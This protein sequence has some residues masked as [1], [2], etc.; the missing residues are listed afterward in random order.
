V[1]LDV[2]ARVGVDRAGATSSAPVAR[3]LLGALRG[4]LD[5]APRGGLRG[6]DG[7]RVAAARAWASRMASAAPALVD[8]RLAA[9]RVP[10]V[11]AL[12][13]VGRRR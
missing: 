6:I 11:F 13:R 7:A 9:P 12:W 2:L 5:D 8:G 1:P 10:L 3:A 4:V